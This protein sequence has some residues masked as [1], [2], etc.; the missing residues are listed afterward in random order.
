MAIVVGVTAGVIAG[1]RRGSIFDNATLVRHCWSSLSLPI[2]V[3]APLAQL[4]FGIKLR[5]VPAHRR[6]DPSLYAL[7]LPGFVLGALVAGHRRCG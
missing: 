5:L 3:L 7:L 4:I 6:R 1:I 2:V